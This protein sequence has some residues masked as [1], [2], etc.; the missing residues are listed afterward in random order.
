[1]VPAL[2]VARY[3]LELASHDPVPEGLTLPRLQ[4][5]LYYAQGWHLGS[6]DRPLFPERIEVG[7]AGPVVP[8]VARG[9]EAAVGND[10]GRAIRAGELGPCELPFR[11]RQFVTAIWEKYRGYSAAGLNGLILDERAWVPSGD[12]PMPSGAEVPHSVLRTYFLR[13]DELRGFDPQVWEKVTEGEE[14]IARGE[15][16]SWSEVKRRLRERRVPTPAQPTGP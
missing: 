9:V 1:M 13:R 4:G 2:D 6:F 3:L 5:L 8:E 15:T 16:V 10:P 14:A 7:L 12:E 11:E